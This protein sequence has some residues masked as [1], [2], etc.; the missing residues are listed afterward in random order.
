VPSVAEAGRLFEISSWAW[1]SRQQHSTGTAHQGAS[2]RGQESR[3][4]NLPRPPF[5]EGES[6][7]TIG[8]IQKEWKVDRTAKESYAAIV[9]A[10]NDNGI[11]S[12]KQLRYISTS[13]KT[14]KNIGDIPVDKVVDFRLLRE[15]RKELSEIDL[16]QILIA[17][18][19]RRMS[20]KLRH[21]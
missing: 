5:R 12:E 4:S 8:I 10:L 14:D 9:R 13:F 15:V 18:L 2:G 7:G 20:I 3:A 21:R 6:R 16:Q 17:I 19:A 11:I 1:S